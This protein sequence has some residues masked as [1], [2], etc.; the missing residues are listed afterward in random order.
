MSI[1]AYSLAFQSE[2][3]D[4]LANI[5]EF[6]NHSDI[7][8]QRASVWTV[9][10]LCQ[11]AIRVR[12]PNTNEFLL[13]YLEVIVS[14]FDKDAKLHI[15]LGDAF[16]KLNKFAQDFMSSH[17]SQIVPIF[18]KMLAAPKPSIFVYDSI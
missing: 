4:L 10:E 7:Y 13:K 8:L 14:G 18:K 11:L 5:L 1:D 9:G 2:I 3:D 17:I 16:R 15:T 12:H 6:C